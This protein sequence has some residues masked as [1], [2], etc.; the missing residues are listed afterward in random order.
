MQFGLLI[1]DLAT[2]QQHTPIPQAKPEYS[3]SQRIRQWF[4]NHISH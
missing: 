2:I 4:S 1:N 3:L